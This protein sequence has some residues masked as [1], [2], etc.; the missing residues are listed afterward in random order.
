M[1]DLPWDKPKKTKPGFMVIKGGK[2]NLPKVK[3]RKADG[4][5]AKQR[6]YALE[7]IKGCSQSE[8]YRRAYDAEKM[9]DRAIA[10]EASRLSMNPN[11]QRMVE[12]GLAE[13]A[14]LSSH[15]AL[16]LR[17][18]VTDRLFKEA[19]EAE[20]PAARIRALELLGKIDMVSMFK[21]RVSTETDERSPAEI[22]EE[23]EA[24]LRAAFEQTG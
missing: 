5:T 7:M 16:S 14:R 24:K 1:T 13:K 22:K 10:T 18:F 12:A 11:V 20:V 15:T 6:A 8:A 9:S 23:L 17:A 4:L 19:S 2:D 3:Q 21:E